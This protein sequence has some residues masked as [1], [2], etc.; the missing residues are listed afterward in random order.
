[1]VAGEALYRTLFE[2]AQ[3]AMLV[4]DDDGC[5]VDANPAASALTGFPLHEL[6]TMTVFDLTAPEQRREG[7]AMWR[8]F[9]DEGHMG[10]EYQL[11]RKD[12]VLVDVEFRAVAHVAP[13]RH[14]SSLRDVTDR[15]RLAREREQL[16]ANEVRLRELQ[17][18][19][20]GIVSHDLRTP[21][22]AIVLSAGR[23]RSTMAG[24]PGARTLERILSSSR[25]MDEIISDLLDYVRQGAG[26]G[27][28]IAPSN[29]DAH[30]LCMTIADEVRAANPSSRITLAVEGEAVGRWDARRLQQMVTNLVVNAV[31]HG[32][33]AV[34]VTSRAADGMW[35]LMVHNGGAPIPGEL[36]PV[37]FEPFQ[38][39]NG[40]PGLGLY[41]VRA[42]AEAHGGHVAV[43]S[44][45]RGGTTFTVVLPMHATA[46]LHV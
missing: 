33:G 32:E 17:E 46:E 43:T 12:C 29:V 40:G 7:E 23:L 3:D 13:S 19:V 15:R 45:A 1:M 5:Y 35:T 4:A 16:L 14:L 44:D 36:M 28:A 42:V 22:S 37:I 25:R 6:L 27:L 18:R 21:L 38:S 9:L 39:G 2:R 24:Q 31:K 34:A 8:A 26:H 11:R 30:Q 41:I 10:G 20:L